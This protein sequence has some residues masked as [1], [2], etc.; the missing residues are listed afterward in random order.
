MELNGKA[1]G[2]AILILFIAISVVLLVAWLGDVDS[3][4]GDTASSELPSETVS[5]KKPSEPADNEINS[6]LVDELPDE[7]PT[8][9]YIGSCRLTV[10]NSGEGSW[11]YATATG[12]RSTH[13]QTCAV[14]PSIIPYGYIVI[15]VDKDG[16]E[17]RF[18]AVDCGGFSGKWVDIFFDDSEAH[19]IQ[20]LDECFGGDF[21]EVWIEEPYCP[22]IEMG[23]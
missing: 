2:I 3:A 10:Y 6:V 9:Q 17:H 12:A 5:V 1:W 16:E 15:I 20:W 7:R 11:G 23:A 19:G 14:D 18:R 4:S 8:R 22:T 21:G 13:M